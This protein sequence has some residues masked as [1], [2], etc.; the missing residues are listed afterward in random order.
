MDANTWTSI[1]KRQ[2]W[3]RDL[4]V[5]RVQS[6]PQE[7]VDPCSDMA[8]LENFVRLT[9]RVAKHERRIRRHGARMLAVANIL[10]ATLH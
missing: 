1:A 8:A 4:L 9:E 10:P 7:H 6:W 5:E 2:L 3:Y